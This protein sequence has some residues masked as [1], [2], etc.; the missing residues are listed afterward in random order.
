MSRPDRMITPAEVRSVIDSGELIEDC[1]ED[2]RGHS[3]L[4]LGQGAGGRPIHVA[5]SPK[6][7]YLAVITA[8]LP[9][10]QEWTQDFRERA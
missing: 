2:A 7:E 6:D 9:D 5:C 8:Y 3:A 10:P 1:P 4:F